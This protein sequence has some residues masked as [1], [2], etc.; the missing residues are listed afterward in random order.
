MKKSGDF[1]VPGVTD[2]LNLPERIKAIGFGNPLQN[3]RAILRPGAWSKDQQPKK[4]ATDVA[5]LNFFMTGLLL[6]PVV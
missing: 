6:A 2:S 5:L 3:R 1:S 4:Q